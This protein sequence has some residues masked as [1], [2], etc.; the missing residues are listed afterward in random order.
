MRQCGPQGASSADLVCTLLA[1]PVPCIKFKFTRRAA[2]SLWRHYWA[3]WW[4]SLAR[5]WR[6][7]GPQWWTRY[8]TL[9]A[10]SSAPTSRSSFPRVGA[11]APL[12][13]ER[14]E[15]YAKLCFTLPQRDLCSAAVGRAIPRSCEGRAC[16]DELVHF[17]DDICSRR[18]GR[19]KEQPC[20]GVAYHHA[21]LTTE[22]R[23]HVEAAYRAGHVCVL[24][25]TSTL[26]AGI[27]LP[28]KRVILRT[29]WQA[30]LLGIRSS[31][32]AQ[33]AISLVL[34]MTERACAL[35]QVFKMFMMVVSGF[36]GLT[37]TLEPAALVLGADKLLCWRGAEPS[38][39]HTVLAACTR[40]LPLAHCPPSDPGSALCQLLHNPREALACHSV[41]RQCWAGRAWGRWSARS[42]CRWSAAPGARGRQLPATPFSWAGARQTPARV[43]PL[44][45]LCISTA[46]VWPHDAESASQTIFPGVQKDK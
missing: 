46:H 45:A 33:C 22:E 31:M 24:M 16:R 10:A 13:Q 39:A 38:V 37:C 35:R 3:G 14:Q 2:P 7:G 8:A 41:T 29:L 6:R 34:C 21:G 26:A 36:A 1:D 15:Q 25:A 43:R 17:A 44:A 32:S 5:K 4:A 12:P 18:E 30:R 20:T 27:N 40:A 23:T 42:T 11:Q 9:W 19:N 28:A